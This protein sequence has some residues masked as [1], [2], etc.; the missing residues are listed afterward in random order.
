MV[1]TTTA[2]RKQALRG[3][4]IAGLSGGLVLT[5]FMIFMNLATGRDVWMGLKIAAFPFLGERTLLPG[6]DTGAVLLGLLSHFL[7]AAIWGTI[8]GF[9]V[10][11]LDRLSTIVLGVLFGIIVWLVMYYI[12]LPIVGAGALVRGAPVGMAVFQH[13]LFGVVVA[14]A[15]M[16]F[17]RAV[18]HIRVRRVSES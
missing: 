12:V 16:P 7:V 2:E 4:V 10:F 6:P 18:R 14:A 3:G 15:F 8:F 13:L 1:A 11:G 17:Q 9:L 5:L